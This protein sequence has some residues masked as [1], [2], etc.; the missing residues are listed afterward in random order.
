MLLEE[1]NKQLNIQDLTWDAGMRKNA[2]W[3]S[4]TYQPGTFLFKIN[5]F[6]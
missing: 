6:A 5:S 3:Q 1:K 4:N 2:C